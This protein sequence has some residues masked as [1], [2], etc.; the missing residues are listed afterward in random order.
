M[1]IKDDIMKELETATGKPVF[2]KRKVDDS[3]NTNSYIINIISQSNHLGRIRGF[4]VYSGEYEDIATDLQEIPNFTFVNDIVTTNNYFQDDV[5]HS[6]DFIYHYDKNIT[7]K[8]TTK[9]DNII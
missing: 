9:V 1:A 7:T 2:D 8:S 3:F 6:Q 5:I 4:I